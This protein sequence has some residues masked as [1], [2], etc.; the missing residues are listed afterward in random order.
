MYDMHYDLL[1]ILYFNLKNNNKLSNQDKLINDC[2]K[3]YNNNVLGG[4]IDL[5]F[6][7]QNEMLDELGITREELQDV[8][9]CLSKV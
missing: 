3:I 5:Y 9:K 2:I 7:S 8:K 1:T 4:I 6:M